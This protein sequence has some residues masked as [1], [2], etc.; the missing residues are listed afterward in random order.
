M[1]ESK[2]LRDLDRVGNAFF[3]FAAIS[4]AVAFLG[5]P[6]AQLTIPLSII[7]VISGYFLRTHNLA[8]TKHIAF[9]AKFF[10]AGACAL[11]IPFLA[12]PLSLISTYISTLPALTS[13]SF[14]IY[15]AFDLALFSWASVLLNNG[16]LR[17]IAMKEGVK[18]DRLK[19]KTAV[20][21]GL[22][23]SLLFAV[24]IRLVS[25]SDS[26][27][28]AIER[29]AAELGPEYAYHVTS[30]RIA[31][32]NGTRSVSAVVVAYTDSEI[33]TIEVAWQE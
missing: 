20:L 22:G 8:M 30:L 19:T 3:L 13:I 23:G 32:N 25:A 4:L 16:E 17:S 1:E 31:S 15:I 2:G 27:Q 18:F 24:I 28:L 12:Y 9:G 7:L 29:A 10:L 33:Q 26:A 6:L 14:G 11:M 5:N 21:F